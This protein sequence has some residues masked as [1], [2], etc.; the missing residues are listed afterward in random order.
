MC[1]GTCEVTWLPS[2]IFVVFIFPARLLVGWAI[3][4]AHRRQEPRWFVSRWLSR[5]AALPIVLIYTVIVFFS[6]YVSWNGVLSLYEQH[7]FL[8]PVPFLG[9]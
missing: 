1:V 9:G 3:G 4:R 7:A 6:Q 5:L 8:L 2:L